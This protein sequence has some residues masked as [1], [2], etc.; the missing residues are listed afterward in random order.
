M[1]QFKKKIYKKSNTKSK[2]FGGKSMELKDIKRINQSIYELD[3]DINRNSKMIFIATLLFCLTRNKDFQDVTK[4]TKFINFTDEENKPIDQIIDLAKNE[5]TKLNLPEK[6]ESAIFNSFKTISGVNT[7]LDGD[8]NEFRKFIENFISNDFTS[9][10]SNDLFLESLYM[11]IDKKAQSSNEGVVLTPTFAAQLMVDM[12]ELDYKTDV[13]ADLCSGTGLFS[14]LSYSKMLSDLEND[15]KNKIVDSTNYKKYKERLTSAII[16]NDNEPKM[17]TLCLA[18]FLLNSLDPSLLLY[19][20]VLQLKKSSFKTKKTGEEV[21]IQ[22]TK[23]IL[24]PP[25]EDK[26]KPLEIIEQN[27][28]LVKNDNTH[29]NK[30]VAIVPPQKFGQKKDILARILNLATLEKV[31]KMQDELFTDSGKS[32]PAS[33]FVFNVDKSHTNDDIIEY[34]DFTDTGYVYLKDSG[35]VDKNG[36]YEQKKRELFERMSQPIE[37]TRNDFE[38]VW[39]NFY[40]VNKELKIEA[41]IDTNKIKT[42][43]DEADIMME[44]IIIKK[45]LAEKDKLINEVSNEFVDEDGKF[46]EYIVRILSED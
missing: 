6:T 42:S 35:L 19:E 30:V 24:N 25:Y 18:N 11:E 12:A 39:T 38:R 40:E 23:A 3:T 43:K 41:Q 45:M 9:I 26:Y 10:K 27:I 31:I 4:L 29:G 15:Y 20:D 13:V 37:M 17:V 34:Y 28:A 2:S 22:P 21:R 7:N 33:I 1:V 16:A 44:N 14:L 5:I 36:T 32:Q 46:E 8:R